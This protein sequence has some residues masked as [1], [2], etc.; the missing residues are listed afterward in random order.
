MESTG[1]RALSRKYDEALAFVAEEHRDQER[2]GSGVPYIAHLLSVSALVLE[3]GGSETE[4]IAALLHDFIEDQAERH[5]GA[6][7]AR[8]ELVRRFGEEVARIVD[9]C[10]DAEVTPKPPWR[11]RKEEYLARLKAKTD[12]S[13]LLVSMADKLHNARSIVAD[14]RGLGEELWSRFTGKREGTLWYYA[15]L[16]DAYGDRGNATLRG[17]LARVITEMRTLSLPR[18]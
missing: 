3:H 1:S 5:G 14:Y 15:A 8:A 9:G 12:S 6:A 4:A 7:A 17:E 13:V 10:T 18:S 11:P 2:K 16:L